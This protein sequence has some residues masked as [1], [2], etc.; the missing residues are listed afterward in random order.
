MGMSAQ[1]ALGANGKVCFVLTVA[2]CLYTFAELICRRT[3]LREFKQ[4]IIIIKKDAIIG[5]ER[6]TL[7][8]FFFFFNMEGINVHKCIDHR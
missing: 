7:G 8:S 2:V 6:G 4:M 3:K 1:Q 5:S